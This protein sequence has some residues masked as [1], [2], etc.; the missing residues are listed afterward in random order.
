MSNLSKSI[1]DQ[2]IVAGVNHHRAPVDVREKFSLTGERRLQLLREAE[3]LGVTGLIAVTTCNRT[4][5]L[6]RNIQPEAL[7]ELLGRHTSGSKELFDENGFMIRGIGAIRH[8][9]RVSTGLEAQILGDLQIIRQVKEAYEVSAEMCM[10]DRVTHRLMQSVFRAHKRSRNETSLGI[11]AATTAYAAVQM[12]RR[13]MKSLKNKNILLA[14]AGKIGKITCKNLVSLGAGEVVVINRNPDR[15][16]KLSQRFHVSVEPFEML[17]ARVVWADLVIVATG[18]DNP[19]LNTSH[20][21]GWAGSGKHKV[22]VDLSVPRNIDPAVDLIEGIELINMDMLNDKTDSTFRQ[23]QANI[24]HVETIIDE[25]LDVFC[26]WVSDQ[27]V[28]PTIRALNDKLDAICSSELDRIRHKIPGET[29]PRVEQL[30]R[31]IM[32]KVMAHSI[33]HL[34]ES[35]HQTDEAADL[36]H[37]IFKIEPERSVD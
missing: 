11:G 16:E 37:T 7:I 32:K 6:A 24:P 21:D 34:R 10:V 5:I 2:Y 31:R 27:K 12:A 25:E 8:F 3:L 9:F 14:G 18:A 20:L 28:V 26:N 1:T 29:M 4:E 33:E 35:P 17:A 30:T 22:L 13:R 23:R 36:L 15:A 19:I